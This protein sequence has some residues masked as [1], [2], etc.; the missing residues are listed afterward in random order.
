MGYDRGRRR[1]RDKRDG[2]GEDGFD[3]FGGG[4]DASSVEMPKEPTPDR[5]K[6]P[7]PP[8]ARVSFLQNHDQIG[9]R[10]FGERLVSLA[11]SNQLRVMTAMLM[12]SPQIPLLFMGEEYGESQPFLFFADY[13]GELGEAVRRGR[14]GEAENFGGMPSGKTADDLPDPLA[15]QTFAASKLR[16]ERAESGAGRAH[17]AFM[18]QLAGIRQRHIAPLLR[19]CNLPSYEIPPAPDGIVAI[20]WSF[21]G[22]VLE[23]RANLTTGKSTVP[24]IHGEPIFGGENFEA[25]ELPGP[26]IV[27]AVRPN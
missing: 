5:P 22:P 17:L 23:L 9:N 1:G 8:Q 13:A 25:S 21:G 14:Q 6:G 19:Q 20:D 15:P 4:N 26:G 10:A 27:A 12:L 18:R 24:P 11:K 16:W 3:P 7:V 2:F